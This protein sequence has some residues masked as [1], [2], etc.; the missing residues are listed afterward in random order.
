MGAARL[1]CFDCKHSFGKDSPYCGNP[2]LAELLDQTHEQN[3]CTPCDGAR[4]FRHACGQQARWFAP[5]PSKTA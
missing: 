5:V 2:R 3:F 1:S 4:D